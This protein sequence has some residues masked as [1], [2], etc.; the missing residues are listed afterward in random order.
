MTWI[1]ASGLLLPSC[2]WVSALCTHQIFCCRAVYT[3]ELL[4]PSKCGRE[5]E[6]DN[7]P[8]RSLLP[9]GFVGKCAV[10]TSDLLLPSY[11]LGKCAVHTSD[12]LLPSCAWVRV[13]GIHDIFCCMAA[14]SKRA[15]KCEQLEGNVAEAVGC[16]QAV[17]C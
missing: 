13:L 17:Q 16:W 4:L 6:G 14:I 9:D 15:F 8:I 1:R 11:F 10:H 7:A 5:K 12:L 2:S 3:S